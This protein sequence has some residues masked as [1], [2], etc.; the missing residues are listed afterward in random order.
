MIS[1]HICFRRV[2]KGSDMT[3][4]DLTSMHGRSS[5]AVHEYINAH[6]E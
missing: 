4:V 3:N 2:S 6:M 5:P 1:L